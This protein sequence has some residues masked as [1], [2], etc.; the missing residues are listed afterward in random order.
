MTEH[1]ICECAH[2]MNLKGPSG[3]TQHMT[4]VRTA[5]RH[6]QTALDLLHDPTPEHHLDVRYDLLEAFQTLTRLAHIKK[7][8]PTKS[9]CIRIF[10]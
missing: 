3:Y 6:L 7:K 4:D 5:R 2:D 1:P 9:R 10:D 8:H